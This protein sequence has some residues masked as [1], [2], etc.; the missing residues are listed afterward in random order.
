MDLRKFQNDVNEFIEAAATPFILELREQGVNFFIAQ[1]IVRQVMVDTAKK[2][3]ELMAA[4]QTYL[5]VIE[6]PETGQ[7]TSTLYNEPLRPAIKTINYDCP[8]NDS[9]YSDCLIGDRDCLNCN[10]YKESLLK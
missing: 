9:D 4:P 5:D 3:Y 2:V 8:Y 10:L 1:A 6:D 7:R